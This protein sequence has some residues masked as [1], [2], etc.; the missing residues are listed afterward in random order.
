[1]NGSTVV[2]LSSVYSLCNSSGIVGKTFPSQQELSATVSAA[3]A[4]QHQ[5]KLKKDGSKKKFLI[6]IKFILILIF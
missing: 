6:L 4:A 2:P 5:Q 1:M 3:A